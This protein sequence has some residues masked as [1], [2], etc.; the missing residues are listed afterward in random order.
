MTGGLNDA[1]SQKANWTDEVLIL[2]SSA[3]QARSVFLTADA[4]VT[5]RLS[6]SR[7]PTAPLRTLRNQAAPGVL[8]NDTGA[9]ADPLT[10]V[11]VTDVSHGALSLE[12]DGSFTYTPTA[13]YSG[14]DS[15]TYKANDGTADSNTVT[16]SLT[17]TAPAQP[18]S[19][20]GRW[21]T[22][23]DSSTYLNH[24][25]LIGSPTFVTGRVSQAIS[26]NG[27]SQYVPRQ[28]SRPDDRNDLAAWIRP[29]VT[30]NTTQDLISKQ[31]VTGTLVDGTG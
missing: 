31:R 21:R 8:A 14:P 26:L 3:S 10:A 2:A 11:L 27:T 6:R 7:M 1:T 19:A 9:D 25:S 24:G 16:V 29:A 4:A 5:S 20:G 22:M 12:A 13:G 30:V 23:P 28:Q 18:R 15:F 17:V